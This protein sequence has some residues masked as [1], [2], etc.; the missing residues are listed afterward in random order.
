MPNTLIPL[1]YRDACNYKLHGEIVVGGEP[2]PTLIA[3]LEAALDAGE[4]IVPEQVGLTHL[5]RTDDMFKRRFPD[6]DDDHPYEEVLLDQIEATDKP[7]TD[8]R[9][10]LQFI[11]ACEGADWVAI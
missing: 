3:R 2:D 10:L 7:P 6:P 8:G 9:T 4:F 1:M 5:A 11:E